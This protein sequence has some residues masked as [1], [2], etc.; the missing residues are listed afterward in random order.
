MRLCERSACR[1]PFTGRSDKRFC[2]KKCQLKAAVPRHRRRLKQKAVEYKGGK[3]LHCGYKKCIEAL[4]F[5]H[6]DPSEKDFQFSDGKNRSWER[7]K[8]ELDKCDM[9]CSNCHKE[10]HCTVV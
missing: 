6:R 1:K 2:C 7:V 10:I 9:V 8:I 3:C 4:E 5:H